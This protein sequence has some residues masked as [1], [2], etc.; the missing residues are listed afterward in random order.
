MAWLRGRP[1]AKTY[2]L[3]VTLEQSET[4]R[5]SR[6]HSDAEGKERNGGERGGPWGVGTRPG[7]GQGAGMGLQSGWKQAV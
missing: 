7:G 6:S 1:G 2:P 3:R 5:T 4:R